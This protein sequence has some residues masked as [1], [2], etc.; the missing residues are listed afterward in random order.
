M[1]VFTKK[2]WLGFSMW[3]FLCL[4][5]KNIV[6]SICLVILIIIY[7]F[8]NCFPDKIDRDFVDHQYKSGDLNVYVTVEK[9]TNNL[10]YDVRTSEKPIKLKGRYIVEKQWDDTNLILWIPF[11]IGVIIQLVGLFA[12]SD[13]DL[14]W[15]LDVVFA[16]AISRFVRCEIEEGHYHYFV[17]NRYIGEYEQS[18]NDYDYIG[19][20]LNINSFTKILCM[21]IWKT[22]TSRRSDKLEEL[23]IS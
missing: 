2:E 10:D 8:L 19:R 7:P 16:R 3:W 4:I 1:S 9:K 5:K 14:N 13:D 6:K 20:R 22:K 17:G 21:P 12:K 11:V 18:M 23:G 15:E